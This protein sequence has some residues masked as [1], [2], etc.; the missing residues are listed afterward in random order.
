M[1]VDREQIV[2][3]SARFRKSLLEEFVER[4]QVFEPPILPGSHLTEI[5]PEFDESLIALMLLRLLPSQNLIDLPENDKGPPA[6]EFGRH[7]G[8]SVNPQVRTANQDR[9][10]L[11]FGLGSRRLIRDDRGRVRDE[12]S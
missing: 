9:L 6:V 5:L 1:L 4:L 10:L 12:S 11:A 7:H 3:L 8:S 2:C